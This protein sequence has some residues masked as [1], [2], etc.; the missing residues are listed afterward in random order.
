MTQESPQQ[1]ATM[2][3]QHTI[4]NADYALWASRFVSTDAM[5]HSIGVI[6]IEPC[7][8]GG[9]LIVA[10]DGVSLGVFHDALGRCERAV[11]IVPDAR[12]L[13]LCEPPR[14]DNDVVKPV[15]LLSVDADDNVR[16]S[17]GIHDASGYTTSGAF[18]AQFSG[19]V[20]NTE[21][22]NW[23][24]V[25]PSAA[26]LTGALPK[27]FSVRGDLLARCCLRGKTLVLSVEKNARRVLL[28]R[29]SM[30][31]DFFAVVMPVQAEVSTI[32]PSWFDLEAA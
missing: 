5:R 9:A 10:T 4:I 13:K 20:R 29:E 24:R 25:I 12:L 16:V 30:S 27:G 11:N 8:S 21:F 26:A 28:V 7:P 17:A 3:T 19:L 22:P 1:R 15:M 2:N 18:E 23:R 32:F 31:T 6:R 14:N